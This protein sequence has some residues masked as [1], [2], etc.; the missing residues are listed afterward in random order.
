MFKQ[1]EER[2]AHVRNC[3][4][5]YKAGRSV[6]VSTSEN[7]ASSSRSP[8]NGFIKTHKALNNAAT[9]YSMT[10]KKRDD[11]VS[12]LAALRGALMTGANDLLNQIVRDNQE[13]V[14]NLT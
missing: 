7:T 8:T 13:K 5:D 3:A 4:I 9:N 6:P 12:E 11:A 1:I 14:T 10:F 2:D